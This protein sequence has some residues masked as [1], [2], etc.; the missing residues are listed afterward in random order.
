MIPLKIE[1]GGDVFLKE[2]K[3]YAKYVPLGDDRK[4]SVY[5]YIWKVFSCYL[6]LV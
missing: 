5:Y 2:V 4:F 3:Q 1:K 6:S